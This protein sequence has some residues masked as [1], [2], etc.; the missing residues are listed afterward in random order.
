MI[1][2]ICGPPGAGKT[3]ITA[4]VRARLADRGVRVR[5]VHS[6]DFSRR[7]YERLAERVADAPETGITLADGTFYR[8]QWQT[9]IRALGD[10][11]IVHVTASLETCLER[12]RHRAEP[13]DEQ[14]VH[15]VYREFDEP[16]ADLEIDTDEYGPDEAADRITAVIGGWRE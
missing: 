14:G 10:V 4:R 2:V 3:T 15:V 6:D 12:N 1:V 9:R 5:T 16:D 7:T 11:R 8:R 13:I